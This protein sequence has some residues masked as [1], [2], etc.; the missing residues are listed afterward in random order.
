MTRAPW[1]ESP[2]RLR[3]MLLNWRDTGHPEGGGSELYCENLAAGLAASGHDVTMLTARYP[4]SRAE[5]SRDGYRILRAGGRF[6]V[7]VRA[8]L[9]LLLRTAGP[10]DVVVDV[11]NG[12]PFFARIVTRRP[13]VV[14]CHHVHR[15]QWR[16]VFGGTRIGNIVARLGWLVESRIAPR[17][18]SG[19]RYVTVS[20]VSKRD[21]VSLGVRAGDITVVYNGTPRTLPQSA[22]AEAPEVVV[23]GRIVPHKRIEHAIRAVAVLRQE[24]P[25]LRLTVVGQGW[26]EPEILQEVRRCGLRDHVELTGHVDDVHKHALLSRAWVLATPSIM[27]GWGLSVVE[28][29][30][31]GTPSVAY[32]SAGGLAESIVDGHTG[33]LSADSEEDFTRQLRR[34]LLDHELRSSMGRAAQLHAQMFTHEQTLAAFTSVLVAACQG[35]PA[36]RPSV[37]VIPP[38]RPSDD[39]QTVAIR[40]D[41]PARLGA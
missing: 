40:S 17:L 18:L 16:I 8:L 3:V 10:F 32:G 23:L 33:L 19:C 38:P 25:D 26:W 2:N 37:V 29:A 12:T 34:L 9:R 20:Q 28:A 4:G 41:S 31:H 1:D 21:L 35:S 24:I 14:L 13:V 30:S 36:E 6:T 27:E 39:M 15:D 11:Q 5:E 7:Y 22:R